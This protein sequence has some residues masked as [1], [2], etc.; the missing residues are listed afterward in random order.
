[1]FRVSLPSDFS[2][3]ARTWKDDSA[4]EAE[5]ITRSIA[6]I[7]TFGNNITELPIGT[8]IVRL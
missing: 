7:N 4:T 2:C 6:F 8:T 5:V 3:A 1:M